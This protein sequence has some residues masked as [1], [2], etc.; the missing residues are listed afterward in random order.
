MAN[1]VWSN[2]TPLPIA[3][4]NLGVTAL[5]ENSKIYALG[6]YNGGGIQSSVDE[7]DPVTNAWSPK[8]SLSTR[9]HLVAAASPGNGKI[10]A[11]GGYHQDHGIMTTVEEYDPVLDYWLAKADIP[12]RRLYFAV[13]TVG[14]KIYVIG[15]KNDGNALNTVEAFDPVTN[16]WSTRAPI[17][18]G[19]YELGAVGTNDGK[20]YTAGGS[21]T[22]TEVPMNHV[23]KYDPS[24]NVWT[25]VLSMPT[26]RYFVQLFE[27]SNGKIY[28]IGGYD[29]Q[30]RVGPIEEYNPLLGTW[31]TGPNMAVPRVRFGVA[32]LNGKTYVVGGT[33]SNYIFSRVDEISISDSWPTLGYQAFLPVSLRNFN[34]GW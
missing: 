23:F 31:S 34:G 8:P 3:K 1:F 26:P 22:T 2:K 6:G 21:G 16:T 29:S 9:R 4:T 11:L 32:S 13:A 10:Y 27:G 14:G 24:S 30:M 15:G 20:I 18:V 28:A 33:V 12:T 17:P 5:R 7:Y 25:Q 19:L